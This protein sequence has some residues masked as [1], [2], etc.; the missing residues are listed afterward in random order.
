MNIKENKGRKEEMKASDVNAFK[1]Q[2][3]DALVGMDWFNDRPD[4]A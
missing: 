4:V 3:K 2:F 1:G